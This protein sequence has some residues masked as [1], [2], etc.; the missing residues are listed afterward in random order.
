MTKQMGDMANKEIDTGCYPG[1]V[2]QNYIFCLQFV[3]FGLIV[4]KEVDDRQSLPLF[5]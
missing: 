5:P 4:D 2:R 1:S 3:A